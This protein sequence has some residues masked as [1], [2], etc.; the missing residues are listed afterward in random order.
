[1]KQGRKVWETVLVFNL[2]RRQSDTRLESVFPQVS[3]LGLSGID[4]VSRLARLLNY[5]VVHFRSTYPFT[6]LKQNHRFYS[7]QG[8]YYIAKLGNLQK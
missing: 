8:S 1:M 3:G 4:L 6:V 5:L 2:G 7:R